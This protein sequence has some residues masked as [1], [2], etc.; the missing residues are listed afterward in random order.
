MRP[1][2][3]VSV[4]MIQTLTRVVAIQSEVMIKTIAMTATV[5]ENR[6]NPIYSAKTTYC[7]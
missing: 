4:K 1:T 7:S 2:R 6:G 5:E 3:N